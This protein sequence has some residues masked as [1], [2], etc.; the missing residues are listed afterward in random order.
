VKE[1]FSGK[2]AVVTGAGKKTGIGYGIARH[3]AAAGAN[4]IMTDLAQSPPGVAIQCGNLDQ[5]TDAAASLA[6]EFG[7]RVLPLEMDV[8]RTESVAAAAA[9]MKEQMG[10]VDFVFNNAGVVFGAPRAVHEYDEEAW[11]AT[12]NVNLHGAFRVVKAVAPLMT[13]R[14][15]AIVNVAS[16]AGK[17]PAPLNGAYSVSKAAMIMMT[18]VMALELG[19]EGIRVNAVCPGLIK[20]D[21]QEGNVALKAL[22]YGVETDEAER[23][24]TADVPLTRMG[25]VDEVADLC[26]FLASERSSYLT[27]QSLNICGGMLT[28]A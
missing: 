9:E 11:M 14:P 20:T 3:L 27:G 8:G 16:K 13:R 26:L 12:V 22:L 28:E 2:T 23:R 10:A 19:P 15:A 25:T 1:S 21:L 6:S 7:V 18:R 5:L 17:S 4:V 24:M